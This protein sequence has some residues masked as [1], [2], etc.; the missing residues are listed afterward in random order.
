MGCCDNCSKYAISKKLWIKMDNKTYHAANGISS[1]NLKLLEESPLHLKNKHLFPFVS[2]AEMDK[3]SLFHAMVLEPETIDQYFVKQPKFDG[4]TNAGKADKAL[5]YA[6]H[7]SK[8]VIEETDWQDCVRMKENTLAIA[9]NLFKG[10]EAEQS[11]FVEDNGLIVKCRPDYLHR[12]EGIVIDLKSTSDISEYGL[13]KSIANY[14]YD[15]QA[16]WYLRTLNLRGIQAKTF[17][18]VFCESTAP[19]MVKVRQLTDTAL[20]RATYEIEEMLEKYRSFLK[21]GNAEIL[22]TLIT[23]G[24]NNDY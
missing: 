24:E 15:R 20:S 22:K 9:G 19:Y 14:R 12:E 6:T 23:F 17:I 18:F 16:A 10:G 1:S 13:K 5:F 21:Y 8:I 11:F 3:G 4:R 7:N 2:T